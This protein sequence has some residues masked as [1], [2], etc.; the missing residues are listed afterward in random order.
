MNYQQRISALCAVL[1]KLRLDAFISTHLPTVRYLC[2]FSGSNSLLIVQRDAVIFLTD[3]RY[4]EQIQTEVTADKKI[5]G[6]GNLIEFASKK[7]IFISLEKIGYEQDHCTITS[8]TSC[9]KFIG[10]KK[11][12]AAENIVENLRAIKEEEEIS[13]I[14]AAAEISDKVFQKLLG[15]IKP[16]IS[17][18][19]I[20]AEISY[21]H[22]KFGAEGDAFETIAASGERGALP[23]GRA[24]NKKIKSGEFVTLDFGCVY[25][26]YHSDMTRTV[27]V[28]KISSEMK[29]VYSIVLEAQEKACN[30][31][32]IGM[33]AKNLD[34]TARNVI[35]KKGFKNYFGHSL[36][37]GVG[38]EIHEA[39]KIS[40]ASTDVINAGQVITIEPGIYLPRRFGIRIEDC[41]VIR[42]GGGEIL[43]SSPKNLIV[44]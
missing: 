40:A 41:V 4:K 20:S 39:P 21:L 8:F 1:Q 37:H 25:Q 15:I 31:I 16:G 5:I 13:L 44:L 26:G 10:A 17:E 38:L 33:K 27:A 22:K 32:A 23:H 18:N 12:S 30:D 14:H 9:Q 24:T 7:N 11:L 6:R 29:K 2:G 42:N 35:A 34:A 19:D 3:F 36:G 28:G 43:S